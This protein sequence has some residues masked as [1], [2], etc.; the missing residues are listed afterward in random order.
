MSHHRVICYL[1]YIIICVKYRY[2]VS[3]LKNESSFDC[4]HCKKYYLEPKVL[5]IVKVCKQ[6]FLG[7]ILERCSFFSARASRYFFC[8]VEL[9]PS[10][11]RNVF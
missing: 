7:S 10:I 11:S 5:K 9:S 3:F 4:L 8:M 6:T 1:I 2:V